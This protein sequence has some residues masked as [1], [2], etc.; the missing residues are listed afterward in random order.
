MSNNH[1]N[2]Q[3]GTLQVFEYFNNNYIIILDVY[4]SV[5]CVGI[6]TRMILSTAHL[7]TVKSNTH[8]H[9]ERGRERER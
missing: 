3:K 1:D 2:V 7:Y 9:R 8:T 5:V 6:L 4:C